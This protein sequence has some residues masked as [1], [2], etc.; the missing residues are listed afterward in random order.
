MTMQPAGTGS[1][2]HP[3]AIETTERPDPSARPVPTA[4][5][6]APSRRWIGRGLLALGLLL[7]LSVGWV[8]WRTYQAYRHLSTAAEQVIALQA[9]IRSLDHIDLP[10]AQTVLDALH[11]EASAAASATSDPLFR[12]AG[13]M[14]W[15]GGNFTAIGRIADTVDGLAGHTAPALIEAATSLNPAALAP[16]NGAIDLAPIVGASGAL[17]TA[18]ADVA[19]AIRTISGTDRR[20]VVPPI[21]RA[22]DTL[23][24]KLTTLSDTTGSAALIGRLAPPLL[25]VAGPRTYLVIFQNL[26]EPRA[27]GGLFGSY[28]VLAVDHGKLRIAGQG[29]GSREL[30]YFDPPM[31]MPAALPSALYGTLPSR[32]AVDANLTPNFPIAAD[33]V[34]QM[35]RTRTGQ[36]VDGVL[37]LD[38]VALSYLLSGAPDIPI[39][40]GL[41]LNSANITSTLLSTAYAL[42]PSEAQTGSRDL[43]LDTATEKAFAAVTNSGIDAKS[44]LSGIVKAVDERRLLLWSAHPREQSELATTRLAGTLPTADGTSP[45]IGV[46]RDDATGGKLGYYAGGSASLVAGS[47]RPDERR[48]LALT[49]SLNSSAPSTGLSPYVN[50]HAAA[51]PYVLRTNILVFAPVSGDLTAIRRDGH[52]L[53]VVWA[54]EGGRKVGMV[55][56]DLKPGA[57]TVLSADL[58]A[59]APASRAPTFTPELR[60]TP[61]VSTWTA[62]ATPYPA[63]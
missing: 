46:F 25:G 63:C 8:G 39:G 60:L 37:A 2:D 19:A 21:G 61:G 57:H 32:Y 29:A 26:A 12:L 11:D 58:T 55:T 20:S 31:K 27:T 62:T 40:N 4:S 35:Y 48:S 24:Q 43:F 15:V 50:G 51:G 6:T 41:A 52:P 9:Q 53:P 18:D 42:Y 1:S 7:L 38:P 56:V 14:P 30:G 10:K 23:Q 22:L 13:H 49:V 17:Q 3:E 47:C 54:T 34:A 45:T 16:R 33:L 36:Q 5:R 59:A 44:A 28:A